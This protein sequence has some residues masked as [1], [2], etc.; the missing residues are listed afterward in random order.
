MDI[1]PRATVTAR[2][3]NQSS[4]RILDR[5]QGGEEI[6]VIRD[7]EPVAVI[8]PAGPLAPPVYP[9][10]TDPM[11]FIDVPGIDGPNLTDDEINETLQGMGGDL[12]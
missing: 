3:L 9:F 12:D 2:E 11:G 4:G 10:R 1:A 5:V 8:V 6:T 7:G